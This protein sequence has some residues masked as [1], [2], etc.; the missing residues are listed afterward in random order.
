[1]PYGFLSDGK[2]YEDLGH[3]LIGLVP[4]WGWWREHRQW[5]PG[6]PEPMPF[7]GQGDLYYI[8]QLD[9]VADVYRDQLGYEIGSVLR[10]VAL[11]VWVVS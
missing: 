9:R 5:P 3:I 11:I 4:G 10:T 6:D 8:T 2:F 1:M 7:T